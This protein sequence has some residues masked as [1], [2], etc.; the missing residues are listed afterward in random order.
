MEAQSSLEANE[1]I[2]DLLGFLPASPEIIPK[3][4]LIILLPSL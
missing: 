3:E 1:Q 2:L 4:L